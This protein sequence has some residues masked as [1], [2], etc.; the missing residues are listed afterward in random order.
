LS[1]EAARP[2][3]SRSPSGTEP[4]CACSRSGWNMAS[5]SGRRPRARENL[6]PHLRAAVGP[7]RGSI[8]AAPSVGGLWR[9]RLRPIDLSAG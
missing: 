4:A 6:G 2:T 3:S 8:G 9:M 1:S 7:A 5:S